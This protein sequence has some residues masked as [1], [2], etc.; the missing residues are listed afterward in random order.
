M[1]VR[2][3]ATPEEEVEF[4]KVS[5]QSFIWKFDAAVDTKTDAPVLGAFS[6]GRIIAGAEIMPF[7]ANYCGNFMNVV[8]ATGIC[9]VPECRRMG[10]VRAIFDK[11]EETAA[12]EGWVAGLLFPFS[13]SY[14]EKFGY[15]NLARMFSIKVPFANLTAI[16]RNTDVILYKDEHFEEISQLH[17]KCALK[18]NLMTLHNDKKFFCG[19]PLE[20][21]DYTYFHR[22][23][24]GVADGYIRFNVN[25]PEAVCV[26]ELYCLNP[27]ALNALVGFLRNYDGITKE[28]IV[29]DQ[30]TG[31]PFALLADR[32]T[33]TTYENGSG[34][35]GRI[36]DMKKLLELNKYPEAYGHFRLLSRDN[37]ECNNGVFDV[38]YQHG[39]AVV[40]KCDDGDYDIAVTPPAAAK[41]LLAGEGHNSDSA[42]Y[43]NGT[44]IKG[45]ASDFFRAFPYRP[46][47]FIESF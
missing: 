11:I 43:I 37:M 18:E 9:S 5:S 20:D 27:S 44:E 29:K 17:A 46:T 16:P 39:K 28:L 24:N 35:A 31:S 38:E 12:D 41:L 6:D 13:I 8:V 33:G 32:I 34:A 30:Y 14:Y 10:G 19:S 36:Y 1:E 23:E 42:A 4:L 40:T 15:A 7:S 26:K 2:Y 45:D 3:L 47:R 25:R 22:D 21:A